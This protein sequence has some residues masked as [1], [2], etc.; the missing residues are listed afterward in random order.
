MADTSGTLIS[1]H[2]EHFVDPSG[3]GN[4]VRLVDFRPFQAQWG[5]L[6]YLTYI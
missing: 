2:Q 3:T 6:N 5:A 1:A 4:K